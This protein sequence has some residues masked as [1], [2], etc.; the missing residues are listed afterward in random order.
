MSKCSTTH[1]VVSY[2]MLRKI[3]ELIS[4]KHEALIKVRAEKVLAHYKKTYTA[5]NKVWYRRLFHRTVTVPETIEDLELIPRS[6][7]FG[8]DSNVYKQEVIREVWYEISDASNLVNRLLN[9]INEA[10]S[11]SISFD[12]LG[13]IESFFKKIKTNESKAA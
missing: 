3:Q 10:E 12:D 13:H 8:Q 2:A 5:Y 6:T 11:V 7:M 9:C 4:E 1:I